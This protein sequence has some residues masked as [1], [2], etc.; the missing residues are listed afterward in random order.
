[1]FAAN[2]PD[3]DGLL[4]RW[5]NVEKIPNLRDVGGSTKERVQTFLRSCGVTDTQMEAV[6]TAMLDE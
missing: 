1:M 5:T 2:Y 4:S 6:R 3:G